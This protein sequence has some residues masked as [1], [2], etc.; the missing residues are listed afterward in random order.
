MAPAEEEQGRTQR[1]PTPSPGTPVPPLAARIAY[2]CEHG[3]SPSL[4]QVRAHHSDTGKILLSSKMS[5]GA[6]KE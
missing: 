6:L 3:A 4:S 2:A 1:P 5:R